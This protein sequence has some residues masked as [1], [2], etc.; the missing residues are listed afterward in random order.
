MNK[1]VYVVLS[2]DKQKH[3]VTNAM[4]RLHVVLSHGSH[5]AINGS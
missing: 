5:Y 1:A 3:L 2:D 4:C